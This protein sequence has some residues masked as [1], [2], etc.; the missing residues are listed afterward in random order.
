MMPRMPLLAPKTWPMTAAFCCAS[1]ITPQ[2]LALMTAVGPPDCATT[3]FPRSVFMKD[4][5]TTPQGGRT[6]KMGKKNQE[7]GASGF[8]S[9]RPYTRGGLSFWLP[10]PP[11]L[12][13]RGV[14]GEGAWL[15]KTP[16]PP[17]TGAR[18]ERRPLTP[19]PSPP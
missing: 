2:A 3:A 5:L 12:R 14:G 9:P 16:S 1:W 4:D 15:P 17:R 6:E 11:V 18:G 13:G 19:D 10:S 8:Y 7:G